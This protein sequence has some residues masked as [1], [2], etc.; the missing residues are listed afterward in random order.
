[1][2]VLTGTACRRSAV[3]PTR[4][5]R[6]GDALRRDLD[7]RAR[8]Q[9]GVGR[10]PVGGGE[11]VDAQ[12]VLGGDRAQRLTAATTCT[13]S[14]EA[15]AGDSR[16]SAAAAARARESRKRMRPSVVNTGENLNRNPLQPSLP[17]C[18][19]AF[20]CSRGKVLSPSGFCH[21]ARRAL[22]VAGSGLG[23]RHQ[24]PRRHAHRPVGLRRTAARARSLWPAPPRAARRRADRPPR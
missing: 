6:D 11:R 5:P 16:A 17:A 3:A 22:T 20:G 18:N 9:L 21:A 10:E 2:V 1:M 12:T 4:S 24:R 19:I 8:E 13:K 14:A 7:R 23:R 15:V